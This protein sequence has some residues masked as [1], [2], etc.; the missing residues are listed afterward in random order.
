MPRKKQ[1][2]DDAQETPTVTETAEETKSKARRGAKAA[3]EKPA[4]AGRI[5][6]DPGRVKALETTLATLKKRYGDGAIMKLGEAPLLKIE[7]IPTGS[8]ALDLAIGVGGIPHG[9]I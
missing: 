5:E 2:A 9:R 6:R 7:A 3:E 1:S 8:L 4:P